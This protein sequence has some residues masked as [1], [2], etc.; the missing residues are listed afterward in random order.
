[1]EVEVVVELILTAVMVPQ[2]QVVTAVPALHIQFQEHQHF[3]AEEEVVEL[4]QEEQPVRVVLAAAEP[5]RQGVL[6][7]VV[8][9]VLRI[10]EVAVAVVL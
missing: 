9:M 6:E 5:V 2:Q 3:M 4:M 10:L 1:M 7:Q 8:K